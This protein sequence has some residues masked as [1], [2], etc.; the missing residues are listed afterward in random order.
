MKIRALFTALRV[1]NETVA[2][3]LGLTLAPEAS[4]FL[5]NA[6]RLSRAAPSM[7]LRAGTYAQD[8]F[9]VLVSSS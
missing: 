6:F 1:R 9:C 4:D 7:L 8:R 3:N 2:L 5:P